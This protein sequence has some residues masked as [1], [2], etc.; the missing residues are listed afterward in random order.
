[1]SGD[2]IKQPWQ[3]A[4]DPDGVSAEPLPPFE[5]TEAVLLQESFTDV[6]FPPTG[7]TEAIINDPGT[8]PDWSRVT[9]GTSPTIA[10]HTAPAMAKFNSYNCSNLASARLSTPVLDMSSAVGP[11]LRFWMSH[12]TGYTT[13]ADR[14]TVQISTD[15]GTT[16]PIDA[17][18]FNR[19]DA[20]C[21]TP[22][23]QEHT[24]DLGAYVGQPTVSIGFLGI[25]AY[26]NN[27]YIDDV[28][29][30]VSGPDLST[31]TKTA[32]TTVVVGDEITYV[33]QVVNS[34]DLPA[35]GATM[36]DVIP[37][38]TT[39]VPASVTCD[40]GLCAYNAGL[41]QIEWSHDLPVATTATITFAVD[42]DGVACGADIGNTATMNS[43]GLIGGPVNRS[44]TTTTVAT[45]PVLQEGF[46]SVTFPPAGWGQEMIPP[47]ATDLWNRVTAGTNPTIAPH[48][49]GAMAQ[50]NSYSFS[51]PGNATRLYTPDLNLAGVTTPYLRFWMSHDSAY[52]EFDDRVQVQ[53]SIDAGMTWVDL[54]GPISRYDAGCGLACWRRHAVDLSAYVGSPAVR[55]GLVGITEFGNNIFVDD[56]SVGDPWY[57]CPHVLLDPNYV[58]AGCNGDIFDYPLTV[59]N[60][61]TATDTL[62]ITFSAIWPT[63]VD[64]ISF[65]LAPGESAGALASVYINWAT[66]RGESDLASLLVT[67]QTSGLT[68]P[69]SINTF[70]YLAATYTDYADVPEVPPNL[71]TRDHS[72][73]HYNGKLYKFGGYD[74]AARNLT[75]VYDIALDTWS[76]ADS[77]PAA[78][79]WFDCVEISGKI[80]CAGGYTTA[81]QS[82]LYIFDPA[83][84]PGSQWTTGA[85]LP[86]NRYAYAG[87]ALDGKYYVLGGYT[88]AITPTCIVYDPVANSWSSI[89][90][91]EVPRRY[92]LAGA[93]GGMIYVAGGLATTS[94]S[95]PSVQ[96]YDPIANVWSSRAPIPY[97]G[98][99]RSADGV[100]D[101]RFLLIVGGYFNDAT[102][103]NYV[104]AYDALKDL[105]LPAQVTSPHLIYATEGDTDDDG[106]FWV[107]SGRLY[108]GSVFSFS[109]YT[110]KVTGCPQCVE[111]INADF[112]VDP[113]MPVVNEP[114]TFTATAEGSP[115]F[116]FSWDFGDTGTGSG[117]IVEHT[118][119]T[120]G[121]FTVTLTVTNCDGAG[122]DVVSHDVTVRAVAD[123]SVVKDDGVTQVL[124]GDPVTYTITVV[125]AGPS[126][127]NGASVI[128]IFP[129][130]LLNVTW[131]CVGTGGAI[132][133]AAGVGSINDLAD[134]PSGESVVY[135]ASGT[136]DPNAEGVL[137]EGRQSLVNTANVYPPGGTTDP[138]L[139]NNS[140]TDID[141]IVHLADVAITKDDG[142]T[143]VAPGD[144]V[145]YTITVVNL[146]P[147]D[148]LGAIVTDSF[149]AGILGVTWTCV[150]S[151]GGVC[152]ASGSGNLVDVATLPFGGSVV[153]TATG[154]VSPDASGTIDNTANVAVTDVTDPNTGNNSAT[155]SDT[156]SAPQLPFADG[157]ESGDTSA[158][159]LTV[160]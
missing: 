71:R 95:T 159:S 6:T 39:Y 36:V 9:T 154:M 122:V 135:T 147:S 111:A 20:T 32:P 37:A 106:N 11:S 86:A 145:T 126:A 90:D 31:S 114:A 148:T 70:N 136:V 50:W 8:D 75:A 151:G 41:N 44:A 139:G 1:M 132:C 146:G 78:R 76:T 38:G 153:Y 89:P 55:L 27:F 4:F 141:D 110:Y 144:P 134:I 121:V 124:P 79:Y 131:T 96:A 49:G 54:G 137:I 84:A 82:T 14:V 143:E 99:V 91:M 138:D 59:E 26:G 93:I 13:N 53:V 23:W 127:A 117:E 123:L 88:T 156:V 101:N 73:V 105:W 112:T 149:P 69:A 64:P 160:P 62:D 66:P 125:N 58:G 107:A 35:T 92:P 150:G 65:T 63:F 19:Y 113:P 7:W 61:F 25:S 60:N 51:T 16:W 109:R 18:T 12:D 116:E 142:V 30:Q 72:V 155:D 81:G 10:P 45:M 67:G 102:A 77:M 140:S 29:V 119:T 85:A 68:D 24:V 17:A 40:I 83:A 3:A 42:T 5:A 118:Y 80:Y 87:V 2:Q 158:W 120:D 130:D 46:E 15:G 100:L 43:V 33:V 21:T 128:D 57:P 133:T 94:A 152:A 22:C 34:G 56:V 28:S 108:E 115:V 48:G 103:S 52:P 74:T 104:I 47:N 129:A 157:F 97:G 98:W